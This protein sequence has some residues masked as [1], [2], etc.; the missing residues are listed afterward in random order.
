LINFLLTHF[1]LG[2]RKILLFFLI[3]IV[4]L[5][6]ILYYLAHSPLLI[7][8]VASKFAPDY[9]IS[10]TR[11]YG[12]AITG[13]EIEDLAYNKHIL[14]KHII[15]RWNPNTLIHKQLSLNKVI[16]EGLNVENIK[17]LIASFDNKGGEES[18][19]SKAP[20]ALAISVDYLA[21]SV[22]S[23]VEENI[24]ITSTRLIVEEA[25][26][27]DN[28][29][30]L[31]EIDLAVDIQKML[32]KVEIEHLGLRL[33][34]IAFD[35]NA[36]VVKKA[37]IFISLLSNISEISYAAKV[38][39]NTL[40]GKVKIA[41]KDALYTLYDLP[42]RDNVLKTLTLDLNVS[43]DA[44][45]AQIH[46]AIP[47]LLKAKKGAFNIDITDLKSSL[48]YTI[49]TGIL[50]VQSNLML[51]TPYAKNIV[52]HNH[53]TL[54]EVLVYDGDIVLDKVIGI[55]HNLSQLF[56]RLKMTYKGTLNSLESKLVSKGLKGSF[57]SSDLK[58]AQLKLQ[59]K[60]PI[61]LHQ[62]K[63]DITLNSALSFE[64]KSLKAHTK[65]LSNLINIDS[66]ISY[67]KDMNL[68]LTI[69]SMINIPTNS[70]LK[71]Y[72]KELKWNA[73]DKIHFK[74]NI[75]ETE[76]KGSLAVKDLSIHAKYNLKSAEIASQIA[77][78]DFKSTIQGK[79]K[80]GLKVR[81]TITSLSKVL[82]SM[83]SFYT[84]KEL[85]DMKGIKDIYIDSSIF[86]AK[87]TKTLVIHEYQVLL[88]KQKIFATKASTLSLKG[89]EVSIKA[90]W[91]NDKI[92]SEGN[93]SFESLEG[94]IHTYGN[95]T[96][97]TLAKYIDLESD[98]NIKTS[99]SKNAT[100]ISGK[101]TLL[102][103]DILYNLARK[104]FA[105]DKDIVI[106]QKKQKSSSLMDNLSL[107]IQLDTKKALSFNQ[108]PIQ[109]KSAVSLSIQKEKKS[110]ILLIGAIELLKG[111]TY[112]FKNKKFVLK[113]SF[114]YFT[115][116]MHSPLI[117]IAIAY[118]AINHKITIA[119]TG[120]PSS[121]H[122]EFTSMP[123]LSK[124]EI[125]S[126]ILFD[127]ANGAGTN[128]AE[129]MMKMMGGVMAKS[130]LSHLGIQVDSLVFGEGDSIEIGKKITNKIT[131]IYVND[132]VSKVKLMY[133]HGKH[134]Q[135]VIG[136]S[137]ASQ[138]YDI[139]Y[140]RDF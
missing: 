77:L 107:N 35:M 6:F 126:I 88:D 15:L 94:E 49:E 90:V 19:K 101:I 55:D 129:D 25:F 61:E 57:I 99:F 125:L 67:T 122:I 40:S 115:G 56:N 30:S 14:A 92:K 121:P 1:F 26:Y 53:L 20:L 18:N 50:K 32:D 59:T 103:G 52:L 124:E 48:I 46:T 139:V 3:V 4:S 36:L 21:I 102:S 17:N 43:K 131:I 127:S 75:T 132:K 12:N 2:L 100:D 113:K 112:H 22:D 114:I 130:A 58:H 69:N 23:F 95:N 123:S 105:K 133:E 70:L 44:L 72:S 140:K 86:M 9:N 80:D 135:S 128:S 71:L 66:N 24:S 62:H 34:N 83:S 79:V 11:I 33:D 138:S 45:F 31:A 38:Q 8:A 65:I 41:I 68:D 96:T 42:I 108:K 134:T 37:D 73:L 117:D 110:K 29:L 28:F 104:K 60:E 16:I 106:L 5:A 76:A 85:P 137:E 10:Y 109:V 82:K 7:E 91:L 98:I 51:D 118:Q 63:V 39:K 54:S 119:I 84:F 97:I 13:L 81:C 74:A 47:Q 89:K 120:M 116:D 93:Y 78:G 64:Q 111:G 27:E 87:N 136:V